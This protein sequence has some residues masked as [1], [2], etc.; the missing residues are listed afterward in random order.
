MRSLTSPGLPQGMVGDVR[1]PAFSKII[2]GFYTLAVPQ[3][4]ETLDQ[5]ICALKEWVR[6]AWRHLA[7]PSLTSFDR[8]EFRNYMK[9]AE[10]ALSAGLKRI[11]D[12]ERSRREAEKRISRPSLD[13]RI[14]R[15][16]T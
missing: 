10:I 2:L 8:R 3:V 6:G 1:Q 9:E 4:A 16:D 15:L 7:D 5:D 13:F 12:R 14:L 11:S